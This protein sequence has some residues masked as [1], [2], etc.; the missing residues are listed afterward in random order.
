VQNGRVFYTAVLP[1]AEV[2]E[3]SKVDIWR[4]DAAD[5]EVGYQR[6]PMSARLREVANYM[7]RPD[8]ILPLGGL[9]NARPYDGQGYG[10][11]LVFEPDP[12]QDDHIQSG[13]LTI[14][15]EALPL[16]IVDMQHRLG[17]LERAIFDDQRHDLG[18]FPVVATI[19]DGLEK[20]EE[21]EQFEIINTTQKKVRTDL[22]R[23][24]MSVQMVEPD[25]RMEYEVRGRLW[26]ARGPI[27]ADWLN[28]HGEIWKGKIQP[29]N[30]SKREAPLA[31]VRETS[32][33]TS[34]KPILQQPL[35]QRMEEEQVA[36]LIDRYWGALAQVWPDAFRHPADYV[37]QKTPG[38]FSLHILLPEVVE[39]V[40]SRGQDLAMEH[41]VEAMST[42][43]DLGSEFWE[44][45]QEMGA[46]RYGSMAGF[47]RLAAELRAE[48]PGVELGL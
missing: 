17:G 42:W 7:E 25:K 38:V 40:R 10:Q 3:R 13:V 39:I 4:A 37:I 33:V 28:R 44:R 48:L 12:G 32:F 8:A 6:E 22:A 36:M 21:I 47:S 26:Q 14:P 15:A 46:S 35:F 34:L 2:I 9:L 19:A 20:L 30:K 24:L 43:R 5:D 11:T 16:W 23:R 45:G 27:V 1:A 41:L 18:N 29:P 31:V